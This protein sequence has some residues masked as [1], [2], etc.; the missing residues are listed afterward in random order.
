MDE[1]SDEF[2]GFS[3]DKPKATKKERCGKTEAQHTFGLCRFNGGVCVP[4]SDSGRF[5]FLKFSSSSV[6]F[7]SN[8]FFCSNCSSNDFIFLSRLLTSRVLLRFEVVNCDFSCLTSVLNSSYDSSISIQL[9]S[10]VCLAILADLLG[11]N[12]VPVPS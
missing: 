1:S 12:V 4:E 8:L 9:R 7:S 2:C 11:F 10:L 3:C 5:L 6:W